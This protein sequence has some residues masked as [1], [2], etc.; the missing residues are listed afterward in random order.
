MDIKRLTKRDVKIRSAY[1]VRVG[2]EEHIKKE[3]WENMDVLYEEY[4]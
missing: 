2:L 1:E 4:K 3:L